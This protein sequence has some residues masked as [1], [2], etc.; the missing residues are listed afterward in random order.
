MGNSEHIG[1]VG[2]IGWYWVLRSGVL[3]SPRVLEKTRF[4]RCVLISGKKEGKRDWGMKGIIYT[5]V[6]WSCVVVIVLD[7]CY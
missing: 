4:V 3:F 2:S 5:E 6:I 7:Y 1:E